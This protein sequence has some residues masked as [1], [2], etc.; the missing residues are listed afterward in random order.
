MGAGRSGTTILGIVLG[1][2][3][4]YFHAGEINKFYEY[5]GVPH[6]L[7]KQSEIY[8][9]YKNIYNNCQFKDPNVTRE[10]EYHTSFY[11]L[12][13]NLFKKNRFKYQLLQNQLFNSIFKYT[14]AD[15][16]IDSSKYAGRLLALERFTDYEISI[17][18]IIRDPV[19]Y[20]ETVS[21][22]GI[23][24]PAQN[25]FYAIIYYFFINLSCSISF[26][27]SKNKKVKIKFEDLIENPENT[28]EK[29]E[30]AL[31]LSFNTS[32]NYINESRLI[33]VGK[34]FEGNRIRLKT[35]IK[36]KTKKLKENKFNIKN[37][38]MKLVNNR[39]Y[40]NI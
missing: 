40:K 13:F 16:L 21:K 25:F 8:K 9:F 33:P 20:L 3:K 22:R 39:F 18:Y 34:V 4:G 15:C 38:I 17:I 26:N 28:I 32:K 5:Q 1:S 29:I 6:A 30:N 19:K 24:Q 23:E 35:E 31:D 12:Y 10:I 11:K 36:F 27:K 2:S 14:G 37:L 7:T